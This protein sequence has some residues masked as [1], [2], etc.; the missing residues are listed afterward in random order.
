MA[1][2]EQKRDYYETLGVA[3]TASA[4]EIKRAYRNQARKLH[5]DVNKAPDAEARFKEVT[6]AYEVL[7]DDTKRR[8]YDRFGHEGINGAAG[9]GAASGF[10]AGAGFPGGVGDIFDIFFGTG[11][12]RSAASGSM[13]ERGDDLRV[14]LEITLEEAAKGAEKTVRYVHLANCETC[15]G[16]GARP[17]TSA[18]TCSQC[19]GTG[20]ERRTQ[21]TLLGVI[22]TTQPCTRCRGAGTT[23]ATPCTDCSGA[24]RLR[25]TREKKVKIPIGIDTGQRLRIA[26]EG[27]AGIRG[28]DPGDLYV[29]IHV[30]PHDTFERRGNDLYMPASISFATAAL[31]GTIHVPTLYGDEKLD[32][33]EGTQNGEVFQLKDKGIPDINGRGKGKL[34]VTVRVLVPKK[35]SNDQKNTLRQWARTLGEEVH[36]HEEK[37]LFGR[38]FRGEK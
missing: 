34:Y 9:F 30:K 4:E 20:Y 24:G 8:T 18:E 12:G 37:G 38:F 36:A 2:M 21:Q 10:G 5:P 1:A 26:G 17:G 29:S 13:A 28:G 35:L 7:S 3:R 31:G 27:D 22:Q 19:K 25:R 16:T 32:I 14:D 11:G 23:I 33:P 15:S 6:E